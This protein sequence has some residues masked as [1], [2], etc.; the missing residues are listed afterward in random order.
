MTL[1]RTELSK[2]FTNTLKNQFIGN[3]YITNLKVEVD[4]HT[5]YSG[6]DHGTD[7]YCYCGGVDYYTVKIL[8][9]Y[10]KSKKWQEYAINY[11]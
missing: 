10:G 1:N 8:V 2:L 6:C 5:D 11:D 7:E 3:E 4:S 9:K